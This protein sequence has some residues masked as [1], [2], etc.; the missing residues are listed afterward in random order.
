MSKTVVV[1]KWGN[2]QGLRLPEAFCRQLGI[3]AGDKVS[4][5]IEKDKLIISGTNE[6]YTLKARMKN[7]NGTR[8]QTHEYDWGES[9]GKETW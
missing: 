9:V 5:S 8:H 6:E 1:S 2:A 4:L 7:W 3:S